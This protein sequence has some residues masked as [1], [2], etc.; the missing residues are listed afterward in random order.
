MRA[1]RYPDG[2]TERYPDEGGML[3]R[4]RWNAI[5][6]KKPARGG[7]HEQRRCRSVRLFDRWEP[8]GELLLALRAFLYATL[9]DNLQP[10]KF[11]HGRL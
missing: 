3:S 8:Q 5:P 9:G 4:R 1:E 7:L 10:H 11:F 6:I 2:E